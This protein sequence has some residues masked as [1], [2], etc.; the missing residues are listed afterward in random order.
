MKGDFSRDTFDKTKH[1]DGVL[2]QQGRVQVDADWNEQRAIDRYR[3]E[4]QG[5]DVI[6]HCGAP[7]RRAGFEITCP[8]GQTIRIGQGHYYVDGILCQNEAVID[9]DQQPDLHDPPA[10]DKLLSDRNAVAG[11]AYLEVWQRHITPLDDPHIREKALGGPDTATRIKTIWQVKVLPLPSVQIA[12]ADDLADL[13]EEREEI[14]EELRELLPAGKPEEIEEV[15]RKLDQAEQAIAELTPDLLCGT[16]LTE[17]T[18]L[19]ELSTGTLKAHTAQS[20]AQTTPCLLPP[21]A[22]YQRLEN[23][24]YR[25]EIHTAGNRNQATFKWSRDN[26]SVVTAVKSISGAKVTVADVGKDEV[27]GFANDQ[28]VEISDDATELSGKPGQLI[29][30]ADVNAAK[31]EITLKSA[32]TGIDMALHPKLRRWDQSGT[33]AKAT[34]VDMKAGWIELEDGVEVQFSTGRY[35]TGDYWLIPARTATGE[36]EWPGLNAVGE[37]E[38]PPYESA[39]TQPVPRPPLGIR[40]HFCRLALIFYSAD[41]DKLYVLDD[42]R[43]LFPPVTELTSLFYVG[44]DGQEALPGKPLAQPLQVGAANGRWPVEGARVRFQVIAGEG[45]L[46]GS[47]KTYLARTGP[48]GIASCGWTLDDTTASQQ[49]QASLLGPAGKRSHLPI[50]FTANLSTA[51]GVA[52]DPGKCPKLSE[53]GADTVQKAIDLLC[54]QPVGTDPRIRIED[55]RTIYPDQHLR[56][57]GVISVDTLVQGLYAVCDAPVDPAAISRPTC[58][59]TLELPSIQQV[60]ETTTAAMGPVG[61]HPLILAAGVEADADKVVWKPT[62]DAGQWLQEAL[63]AKAT[64]EESE[65]ILAHLTLKGNFIWEQADSAPRYLDGQALG[66]PGGGTVNNLRLPSGDGKRGGDF[67]MWFWVIPPLQ[68]VPPGPIDINT[69]TRTELEMLPGVGREMADRIIANRPY[70]AVADLATKVSGIGRRTLDKIG[71]HVIITG[72]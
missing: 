44:G 72:S 52:Y 67:E 10:I 24:L 12:K 47:G 41:D 29:Q 15:R 69:A 51:D 61:Y 57:G 25:V 16:T 43:R 36:I 39:A 8:D 1:Y 48:D 59:V 45:D 26:G 28:W 53:A 71:P 31:K 11:L 5:W 9:Y 70:T 58:F 42:C 21:L 55:V 13:V 6:G 7:R 64:G 62:D 22:G 60:R 14:A 17:W 54:S 30:I 32:P 38:W 68:I 46:E 33:D 27:L 19:A 37:I 49:V 35:E 56:N 34:G 40:H 63:F 2:M 4:T 3:T 66:D 18:N 23:Q 50:R 65:R 20:T